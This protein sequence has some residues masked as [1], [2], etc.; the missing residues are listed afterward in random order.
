MN[1]NVYSVH[2]FKHETDGWIATSPEWPGLTAIGD[3]PIQAFT[4]MYNVLNLAIEVATED[5]EALP[6]PQQFQEGAEAGYKNA[7]EGGGEQ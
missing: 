5:G 4:E 3:T 1:A 7:A 2:V 6:T